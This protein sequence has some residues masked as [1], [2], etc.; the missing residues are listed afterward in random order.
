MST[1]TTTN[2]KSHVRTINENLKGT[3]DNKTKY[4]EPASIT[5]KSEKEIWRVRE[6]ESEKRTRILCIKKSLKILAIYF[7][8]KDAYTVGW[9]DLRI[10]TL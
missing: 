3:S 8:F 7:V 4:R 2:D 6:S 9:T 1:L 5:I 10:P